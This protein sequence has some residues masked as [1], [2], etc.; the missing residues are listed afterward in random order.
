M[1]LAEFE[2]RGDFIR[3]HIGAD[4]HQIRAMLDFLELDALESIIERAVPD[5][6]VSDTPLLLTETISEQAVINHLARMRERKPAHSIK[7][8]TYY[9]RY[10]KL[11]MHIIIYRMKYL[12]IGQLY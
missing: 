4:R 7:D 10:L 6:I 9:N 5:D 8:S 1:K 12:M 11:L 2:M 3:R